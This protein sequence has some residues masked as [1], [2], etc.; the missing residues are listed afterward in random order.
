MDGEVYSIQLY[1]IKVVRDFTSAGH[2]VLSRYSLS[3]KNKRWSPRN[4]GNLNSID[5]GFKHQF[6]SKDVHN[7]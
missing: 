5:S 3:S 1:V 6:T 7:S 4:T 2:I